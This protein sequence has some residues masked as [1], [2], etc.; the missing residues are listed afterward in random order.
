MNEKKKILVIDD[1]PDV[2]RYLTLVLRDNGFES[3]SA[4]NAGSALEKLASFQ[5]DLI[6]LDI[7]MPKHSGIWLYLELKASKEFAHMPV[8]IISG[9]KTENEFNFREMIPDESIPPPSAFIEK[10]L[11][12]D[13]FIALVRRI[14]G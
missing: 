1:E 10:P 2:V 14:I 8:I 6:C 7:M 5:P 12:V 13:Q 11:N 9:I 3:I 4:T